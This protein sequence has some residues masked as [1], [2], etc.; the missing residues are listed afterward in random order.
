MK[1]SDR[2]KLILHRHGIHSTTVQPEFI[3]A[4]QFDASAPGTSTCHEPICDPKAC[5]PKSCCDSEL[6]PLAPMTTVSLGG[7]PAIDTVTWHGGD[8]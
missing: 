4:G 2:M 3:E 5:H 7:S 6:M 1:I 8:A